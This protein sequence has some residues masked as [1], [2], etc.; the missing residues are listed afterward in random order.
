MTARHIARIVAADVWLAAMQAAGYRCTCIGGCGRPH[1]KDSAG[2]CKR[3]HKPWLH[4][5]AAPARP[6][7]NPHADMAAEQVAYCPT[8]YDGHLSATQRAAAAHEIDT[9]LFNL[10]GEA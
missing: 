4:L 9:A 8:C 1:A 7:G 6:T 10:G 3:E 5:V 2:R